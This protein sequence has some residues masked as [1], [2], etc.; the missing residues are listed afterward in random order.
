MIEPSRP[1]V[2][3]RNQEAARRIGER[4]G[5]RSGPKACDEAHPFREAA[6]NGFRL[7]RPQPQG[8]GILDH[9]IV[10]LA[11]QLPVDGAT[12]SLSGKSF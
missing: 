7:G 11:N 1:E 8:R 5:E 9:L 12:E 3:F 10:L 2:T 6:Q 4:S